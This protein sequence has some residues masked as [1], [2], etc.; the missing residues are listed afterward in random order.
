MRLRPP[1]PQDDRAVFELLVARDVADFGAPDIV[2]ED[3]HD[4]WRA[5]DLDLERDALIIEDAGRIVAY[6]VLHGNGASVAV[7]PE[8]EGRGIGTRLLGW[9]EQRGREQGRSRHR[10]WAARAN[11][12]G[13]ELLQAAGYGYERTYSRMSRSLESGVDWPAPMP[14]I[15]VRALDVESDAVQL[16][17]VDDAAFSAIPDYE[18]ETL[19]IFTEEHL[20]A[21]DLDPDLSLVAERDGSV[22]GFL[23]AKRWG[24][25]SIGFVDILAV[26]PD[27]QR[28]GIGSHLLLCAFAGFAAAGLRRAELGVA[29]DNPRALSLYERVGMTARFQVDTYSRAIE[30]ERSA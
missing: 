5:S 19:A 17:A 7:H 15:G 16:H 22:I 23:L 13:R 27:H 8:H 12:A 29:S 25:E 24:E 6:A 30:D 11:T 4:R 18:P 28:H 9:A 2:L 26:R 1:T 10:Q 14:D 20:D 3:L 21:H